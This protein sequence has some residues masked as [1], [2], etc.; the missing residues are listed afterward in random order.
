MRLIH[1]SGRTYLKVL[2]RPYTKL[3]IRKFPSLGSEPKYTLYPMT[4]SMVS[5]YNKYN[6][7]RS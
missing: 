5:F 3:Q 6:K 7:A 4:R 1:K 2:N